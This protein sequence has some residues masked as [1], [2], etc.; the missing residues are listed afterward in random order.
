[1]EKISEEIKRRKV[2]AGYFLCPQCQET[3]AYQ[4]WSDET[5]RLMYR[6]VFCFKEDFMANLAN[7]PKD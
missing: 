4:Y 5:K 6:C 1:M 7:E 2:R 3:Q